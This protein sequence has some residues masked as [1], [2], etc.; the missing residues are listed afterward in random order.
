MNWTIIALV[1]LGV[2]AFFDF[3]FI[4]TYFVESYMEDIRSLE[5]NQ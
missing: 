2:V 5:M 1:I 3:Y 4:I